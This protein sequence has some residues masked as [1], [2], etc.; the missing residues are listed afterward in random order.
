M[1][2]SDEFYQEA[3]KRIK[4]LE[5]G[6]L[7]CREYLEGHVDVIDGSYGEPRPNKAMQ[8][9]IMIDETLGVPLGCI[10]SRP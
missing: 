7:E 8:L 6:L 1:A 2:I 3:L 10:E 5:A 9:T 4:M